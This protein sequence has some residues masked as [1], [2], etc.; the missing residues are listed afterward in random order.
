MTRNY[1]D[2]VPLTLTIASIG[3]FGVAC[4]DDGNPGA[5]VGN[6]TGDMGDGDGDT[7]DGDG[8]T[9]D[10]D[11]D[12]GDGD[13]GD[14]DTGSG[15]DTD[16]DGIPDSEDNCPADP[17]PNQL[18]FDGNGIGNVC[19]V[20][21][22]TGVTGTLNTTALADGG[23]VVGNCQIPLQIQV[24]GGMVYVQLDDEAAIAGFEIVEFQVAD[25][26]DEECNLNLNITAVVSLK[27]FLIANSGGA[28]P[29]SMPH[30]LTAHNAGSIAGNSDMPHPVL[31][32]ATIEAAVGG[33][34]PE[35]G[36]LE[37]DGALPIFTA[38]VTG[39][40]AMGTMSFADGQFVLA[41]DTFEVD[42]PLLGPTNI[43]FQLR[44]LVGTLALLP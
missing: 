20:Q 8:D 27:D 32:T 28:F 21:M 36:P 12:T 9:G 42:A 10:G 5:E 41:E 34:P 7:G 11:G 15:V 13:T 16:G 24:T 6:E 2:L 40:G 1:L 39:A 31:S 30:S 29:V 35:A 17:N 37:L 44:G 33:D 3:L 19:D 23:G 25:I 38:N 43:D 18:D 22:F 26:L 14:G 4:G